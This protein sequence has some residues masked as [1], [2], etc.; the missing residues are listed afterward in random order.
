MAAGMAYSP[1][2]LDETAMVAYANPR[3]GV[4]LATLEAAFDAE[5]AHLLAEG[6]TEEEVARAQERLVIYA[7]LARDSLDGPVRTIGQQ[8]AIGRTVEDV[9]A[10]PERIRAVTADQVDAAARVVLRADRSVT[11]VLEPAPRQTA[12]QVQ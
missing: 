7:I 9:E 2:D 3:P 4:D 8:L 11:G 1:S 10:W 6:V 5:I 12:Q